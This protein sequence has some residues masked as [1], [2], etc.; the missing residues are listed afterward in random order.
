MDRD[1]NYD[2][3]NT[4]PTTGTPATLFPAEQYSAYCPTP[5]MALSYTWTALSSKIDAMQ[6]NGGTDQAI[7]LQW[8]WQSLTAAPFTIP[9]MDPLYKYQQVIILLTDGLNTQD[10]WYGNGSTP[11]PQVDARQQTLCDNINAA[12]ITLYTVQV[13]TDGSPTS[14]L[15]QNCAGSPGKYPDSSKFFLL[16]SSTEIITTFNQI[17]TALTNL[18][19]AQ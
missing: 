19:V 12:G 14:T 9:A 11:S 2:T 15:L 3:T 8:G 10:R 17:G 13:N 6:P 1:Q 5:L 16:T 18:Y 4:A 7:G